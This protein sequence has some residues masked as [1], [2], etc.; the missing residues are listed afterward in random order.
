MT[1]PRKAPAFQLTSSG[2]TYPIWIDAPKSTGGAE[3][4]VAVLCLDADD[5]FEELR[6]ARL[7][8]VKERALVPLLLVGVG[9]GASY[10]KPGNRRVTDYTPTATSEAPDAGDA[11]T[12]LRF[13]T[14]R[15][16]RELERRYPVHPEI[17]GIAG[18]SLGGLL[19]L[20]ALFR[21]R[22]F[23]NRVLAGSPSIWWG[24]RAILKTVE[25]IQSKRGK[26][27]AKLF[28]SI[29]LK[30]GKSMVGDVELFQNQLTT[31]P[32]PELEVRAA[33]FPGFT[34]F[35]A[36]PITFRTGLAELFGERVG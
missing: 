18:Y 7:A 33:R 25:A 6:K 21:R 14:G 9:Y 31:R 12:F 22:P 35:N 5:Q 32:V 1:K 17:R 2:T 24:D 8:V 16:W 11:E 20:H 19:A 29:G 3:S 27:P 28:V 34:H 36:I 13:L 4:W 23:F 26:L 10:G 15:L 30:D